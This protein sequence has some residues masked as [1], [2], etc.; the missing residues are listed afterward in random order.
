MLTAYFRLGHENTHTRFPVAGEGFSLDS[1]S[2]TSMSEIDRKLG[3]LIG[4]DEYKS[5]LSAPSNLTLDSV[6][7]LH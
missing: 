5:I 2:F 7:S 4:Q 3:Q 6:S 1:A